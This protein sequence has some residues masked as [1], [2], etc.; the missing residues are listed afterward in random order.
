M[1]LHCLALELLGKLENSLGIGGRSDNETHWKIIRTGKSCGHH[2]EHS[3]AWNTSKL[4]LNERQVIFCRCLAHA[5]WLQDHST[6]TVVRECQLKRK[7]CVRNRGKNFAGCISITDRVV[8]LCIRRRGH[9][10]EDHA[11]ILLWS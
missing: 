11:L 1:R 6:K 2:R 8:Y 10:A 3:N 7:P 5:P 9:D 4:L